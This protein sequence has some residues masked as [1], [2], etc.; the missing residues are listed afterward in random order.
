MM[1]VNAMAK[2]APDPFGLF[3]LSYVPNVDVGL[4]FH[5]ISMYQYYGTVL[6]GVGG[7]SMRENGRY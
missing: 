1:T 3:R 7:R 5:A 2:L 4:A 6:Q